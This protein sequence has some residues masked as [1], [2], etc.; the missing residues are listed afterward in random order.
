[1][2]AARGLGI[3]KRGELSTERRVLAASNDALS[4]GC[5]VVSFTPHHAHRLKVMAGRRDAGTEH[6]LGADGEHRGYRGRAAGDSLEQPRRQVSR[7]GAS[8]RW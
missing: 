2:A 5:V 4:D 1:M 3:V 8:G 6:R 7:G